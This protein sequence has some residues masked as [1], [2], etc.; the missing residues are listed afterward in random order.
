[1]FETDSQLCAIRV[2]VASLLIKITKGAA[3]KV[4]STVPRRLES[5]DRTVVS[6]PARIVSV[7]WI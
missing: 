2:L 4:V 1:M 3:F 5:S 6:M 7:S